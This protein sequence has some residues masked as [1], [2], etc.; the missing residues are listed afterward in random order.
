MV[1]YTS[2]FDWLGVVYAHFMSFSPFYS[3]SA[4]TFDVEWAE[5]SLLVRSLPQKNQQAVLSQMLIMT[6]GRTKSARFKLAKQV[7]KLIHQIAQEDAPSI[8][9]MSN[10]KVNLQTF[11]R[12]HR[13]HRNLLSKRIF[14]A[15]SQLYGDKEN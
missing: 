1:R 7:N 14:E 13:E 10:L 11:A 15:I 12:L 8:P 6:N 3:F 5:F 4:N 9:G 2:L